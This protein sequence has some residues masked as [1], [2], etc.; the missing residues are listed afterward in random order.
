MTKCIGARSFWTKKHAISYRHGAHLSLKKDKRL[1]LYN[2]KDPDLEIEVV[3]SVV[4]ENNDFLIFESID[5]EFPDCPDGSDTMYC[6]QKYLQ[7]GINQKRGPLWKEGIISKRIN[8]HYVGTS[9]GALGDSGAGIFNTNGRFI[10][11]SVGKKDFAFT[12]QQ[13]PGPK[14]DYGELAD[15]HPEPK[16][17]PADGILSYLPVE[18]D[19]DVEE[20]DSPR[21]KKKRK[22]AA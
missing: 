14:I 19:P 11:I 5:R 6:G 15:H 16:I 10:G 17:I 22:R 21:E 18:E 13:L 8:G 9:H 4:P 12:K 1:V 2:V 7:L 20:A 3:V